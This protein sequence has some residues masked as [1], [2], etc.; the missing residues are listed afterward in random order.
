MALGEDLNKHLFTFRRLCSC[1]IVTL[2]TNT[3]KK[4]MH[5]DNTDAYDEDNDDDTDDDDSNPKR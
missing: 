1:R 4:K 5:V 3:H 2:K